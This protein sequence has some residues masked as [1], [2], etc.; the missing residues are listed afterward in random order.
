M[1]SRENTGCL[2]LELFKAFTTKF[3][4]GYRDL[5]PE[6]EIVQHSFFYTLYLVASFREIQRSQQFYEDKFLTAF[7]MT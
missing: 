3:N 1:L 4:W 2:Y 5:Y 6:T 7:P